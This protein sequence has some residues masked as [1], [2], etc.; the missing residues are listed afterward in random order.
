[1][2]I[3]LLSNT[4]FLPATAGNR[5]R[6]NQMVEFL[7][8]NGAEVGML[9]LPAAD[10]A[11]W[12]LEAMRARLSYFEIATPRTGAR[13]S[14]IGAVLARRMVGAV[15]GRMRRAIDRAMPRR[16]RPLGIDDWCPSWFRARAA[17]VTEQLAP[18]V[19]VVEY[20]FLSACLERLGRS[21]SRPTL[22]V[23]DTHDIMHQRTAAYATA[24]LAPQWFHTTYAEERRGLARAG[25]VLAISEGDARVLQEMLP[26]RTVLTVPHGYVLQR[27]PPEEAL[28]GRLLFVASHND[29]NVHGLRWFLDEVWPQLRAGTLDPEL[30]VCGQICEKLGAVPAGVILRGFTPS[31]SAEYANARVVINPV[32]AGTGL[33]VKVVEALCHGRPVISTQ[34]GAEGISTGESQGVL[35]A[36]TA[37]EFAETARRLLEH[38]GQCNRLSA[39]AAAHAT[40]RFSPDSAFAPFMDYLAAAVSAR[41][42]PDPNRRPSGS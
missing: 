8:H 26:G 15:A 7:L 33:K 5:A 9:M 42:G 16:P 2:R 32:H 27:A 13:A 40:R 10:V 19:V 6:I 34:A 31:L 11:E 39:A 23:I 1:M 30:V 29:L 35:I 25:I 12:D 20:V 28:A 21:G 4:P 17:T 38:A 3:L 37:S 18:D 36:D 41:P 22:T 24:G 14:G